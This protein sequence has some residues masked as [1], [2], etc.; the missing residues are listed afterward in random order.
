VSG[1]GKPARGDLPCESYFA[2]P[3]AVAEAMADKREDRSRAVSTGSTSYRKQAQGPERVEGHVSAE[4]SAKVEARFLQFA[5]NLRIP[6][7]PHL[8]KLTFARTFRLGG[9]PSTDSAPAAA[10]G[11]MRSLMP[12]F[13]TSYP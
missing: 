6:C 1:V 7:R 8:L 5:A 9:R 12:A 10:A 4:A 2:R 13:P 3:S 11:F